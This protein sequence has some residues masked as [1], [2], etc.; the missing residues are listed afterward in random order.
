[1][2]FSN[3]VKCPRK[4]FRLNIF[5]RDCLV[6]LTSNTALLN[7]DNDWKLQ[8]RNVCFG[9]KGDSYGNFTLT[10]TGILTKLKLQHKGEGTLNCN[11]DRSNIVSRWG[12]H[13][14]LLWIIIAITNKENKIIFPKPPPSQPYYF[15]PGYHGNSMFL[16]FNSYNITATSGDELR[17]WFLGDLRDWFEKYTSGTSCADV[18]AVFCD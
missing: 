12:C 6:N 11:V 10:H 5:V 4:Y 18:H 3:F 14:N 1:M 8:A 13:E 15:L 2:L 17:I 7:L 9:A 16:V